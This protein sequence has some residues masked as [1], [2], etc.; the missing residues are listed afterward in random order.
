MIVKSIC[1]I[2]EVE[3]L[4]EEHPVRKEKPMKGM[5]IYRNRTIDEA[6]AKSGGSIQVQMD[7][8]KFEVA[9]PKGVQNGQKICCKGLG[10]PGKNGGENGDLYI[11]LQ[12]EIRSE[13]SELVRGKDIYKECTVAEEMAKSGGNIR[14]V[15]DG[16]KFEITIPEDTKNGQEIRY[17]GL[18]AP[19][20]NGGDA[21]DM[22]LKVHIKAEEIKE[23]KQEEEKQGEEKQEEGKKKERGLTLFGVVWITGSLIYVFN[24]GLGLK[25]LVPA[26]ME[27]LVPTDIFGVPGWAVYGI[28]MVLL[29]CVKTKGWQAVLHGL[30]AIAVWVMDMTVVAFVLSQFITVAWLLWVLGG[31]LA[32]AT[33]I[34]SYACYEDI[35]KS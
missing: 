6:L 26:A 15:K 23:E 13:T 5:D 10:V 34:Y 2:S 21:G 4:P 20:K 9:I 28:L 19:G 11:R 25:E 7:G 1:R 16:K 22:Y 8:K 31:W 24:Q 18:G 32:A 14:V 33:I 27:E 29:G 12:I 17:K 35:R 30:L 3:Q